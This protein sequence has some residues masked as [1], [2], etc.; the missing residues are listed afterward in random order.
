MNSLAVNSSLRYLI[1]KTYNANII[2]YLQQIKKNNN[3]FQNKYTSRIQ[4]PIKPAILASGPE[5]KRIL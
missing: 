5:L 2:L 3:Y 4:V 1:I